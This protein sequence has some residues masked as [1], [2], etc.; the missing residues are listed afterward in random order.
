MSFEGSR[1]MEPN[2]IDIRPYSPS[3]SYTYPILLRKTYRP[4][5]ENVKNKV[6]TI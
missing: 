1:K 5:K 3:A 2:C 6:F 4:D